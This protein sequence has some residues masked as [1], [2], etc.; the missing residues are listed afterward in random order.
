MLLPDK[1]YAS[2]SL[3]ERLYFSGALRDNSRFCESLRV[4]EYGRLFSSVG[5]E[6]LDIIA[7]GINTLPSRARVP[8]LMREEKLRCLSES[9]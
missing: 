6:S 8:D 7:T 2:L 1:K 4:V 9:R 5:A 3:I